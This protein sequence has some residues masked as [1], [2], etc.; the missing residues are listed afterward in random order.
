MSQPLVSVIMAVYNSERYII[1][2]LSSVVKQGVGS[3]EFI[4]VNDGS[5]DNTLSLIKSYIDNTNTSIQWHIH[6]Q[7]NQGPV[8][9]QNAALDDM[10][11]EYVAFIDAD[12]IWVI[13]RLRQ[14]IDFLL[15][16]KNIDMVFGYAKQFYSPELTE[17]ECMKIFCSTEN[18]PAITASTMCA[19]KSVFQT[20]GCFDVKW[21][22]GSFIDW[23]LRTRDCELNYYILPEVVF[24]RRLHKNNMGFAQKHAYIDYVR[25]LKYSLDRKKKSLK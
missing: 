15:T 14:Q 8:L 20:A 4:I 13:N 1:E 18:F 7:K 21:R 19:R 10:R 17:E 23:F 9:A 16:H 11:G 25:I 3:L 5:T 2:A 22:I 24:Y 6:S 12:D